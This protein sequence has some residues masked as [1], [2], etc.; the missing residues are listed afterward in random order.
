VEGVDPA[1]DRRQAEAELNE[2]NGLSKI[3]PNRNPTTKLGGRHWEKKL[4]HT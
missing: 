2:F 1:A 3:S 4:E